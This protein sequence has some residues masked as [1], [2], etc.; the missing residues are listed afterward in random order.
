MVYCVGTVYVEFLYEKILCCI[1]V[2]ILIVD[3]D[4]W[5]I[6]PISYDRVTQFF[7][8]WFWRFKVHVSCNNNWLSWYKSEAIFLH[9]NNIFNLLNLRFLIIWCLKKDYHGIHLNLILTV[10]ALC[11]RVC[12]KSIFY[13]LISKSTNLSDIFLYALLSFITSFYALSSPSFYP[14]KSLDLLKYKIIDTLFY[15]NRI[16]SHIRI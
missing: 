2:Y 7:L 12:S 4:S 14:I 11:F 16:Q 5:A 3:R 1:D 9:C 8:K 15:R 13:T 10:L 6:W